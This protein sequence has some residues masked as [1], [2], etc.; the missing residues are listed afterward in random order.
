MGDTRLISGPI[1]S[2][3][4]NLSSLEVLKLPRMRVSA[5]PPELG[6]LRNLEV[7]WLF[8]NEIANF[9]PE[10]ANLKKLTELLI[11]TNRL[12]S[13]PP[14]IGDGFPAL[15]WMSLEDN[16]LGGP[17]PSE[18]AQLPGL[19][20]L[21]L[22]DN[23]FTGKIPAEFGY[24]ESLRRLALRR[25]PD[26]S[27]LLPRSLMNRPLEELLIADTGLCRHVD[28]AFKEW[29]RSIPIR[30][31]DEYGDCPAAEVERL[32]LEELNDK[33]GGDGWDEDTGWRGSGPVGSWHGV[34]TEGGRV[35]KIE[36]PDNSLRG[37]LPGGRTAVDLSTLSQLTELRIN[38][39]ADLEGVFDHGLTRLEALEV[40]HFG[41]TRS[42]R[43]RSRTPSGTRR[44]R[45]MP[46]RTCSSAAAP[47]WSNG[48]SIFPDGDRATEPDAAIPSHR[49][50]TTGFGARFRRSERHFGE[51]AGRRS[52]PDGRSPVPEG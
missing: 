15:A 31:D 11:S 43:P 1:P 26:L 5:I 9:P 39:N 20:W 12:T 35:T 33:T 27:G 6:N 21:G 36:L 34:T 32:A 46:A 51:S 13:L 48:R 50:S 29:W 7:L 49:P 16:D 10:L 30:D 37:Q 8:D 19:S 47:S 25:L 41:G 24:Q 22:S 40:L 3:W 38:G 52:V 28:A 45:R 23:E 44:R 42:W 2:S 18:L 14:A 4:G 17:I